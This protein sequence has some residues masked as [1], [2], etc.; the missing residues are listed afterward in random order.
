MADKRTWSNARLK[1]QQSYTR[2]EMLELLENECLL[3]RLRLPCGLPSLYKLYNKSAAFWIAM[4]LLIMRKFTQ[5]YPC[6]QLAQ[7]TNSSIT[8]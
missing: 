3:K 6:T 8:T 7:T 5:E 4:F 1:M 2:E